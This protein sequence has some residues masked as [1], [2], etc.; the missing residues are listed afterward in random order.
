MKMEQIYETRRERLRQAMQEQFGGKQAAIAAR[1][2]RQ[3]D[4]IS[5]IFTGRK[6]LAEDLAREFEEVLGKPPYWLDGMDQHVGGEWPFS[7]SRDDYSRLEPE[8]RARLDSAFA[9]L[10]AGALARYSKQKDGSEI[11]SNP[12]TEIKPS[13]AT[14]DSLR[15]SKD[16]AHAA[17]DG[18]GGY[19]AGGDIK[20]RS[21]ETR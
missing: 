17:K 13:R 3:A 18:R 5:R 7:V 20:K 4:Y 19:G 11:P 1:L 10:V 16:S 15:R 8:D 2:G 6:M 9:D 12:T 14:M 21:G